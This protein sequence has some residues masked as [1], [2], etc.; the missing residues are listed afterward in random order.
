[1]SIVNRICELCGAY[2]PETEALYH[3]SFRLF[4]HYQGCSDRLKAVEKDHSR[5]KRGR[6]RTRSEALALLN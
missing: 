1:M 5:S 4:V 6:F 2:V 3:A